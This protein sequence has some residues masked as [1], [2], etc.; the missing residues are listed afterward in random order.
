MNIYSGFIHN[1]KNCNKPK[2]PSTGK[3]INKLVPPYN[4]RLLDIKY[5]WNTDTHNIDGT[6][7]HY[8]KWK[9]PYSKGYI[10]HYF[11]F[12][13]SGNDKIIRTENRSMIA[14]VGKGVDYKKTTWGNF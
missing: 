10:L 11:I 9:K 1:F 12:M 6:Q 5:K 8:T 2:C 14:Q 4:R 7:M 13:Y 3:W